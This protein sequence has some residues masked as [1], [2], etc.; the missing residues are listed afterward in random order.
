MRRTA[1]VLLVLA[2][3]GC[4]KKNGGNTPANPPSAYYFKADIN[5][6]SW[7][8]NVYFAEYLTY[9]LGV[10]INYNGVNYMY[11]FSFYAANGDTSQSMDLLFPMNVPVNTPIAFDSAANK[12]IAYAVED[13]LK[14]GKFDGWN[15]AAPTGGS[16][17][18]TITKLDQGN[19]IVEGT[20]SGTLGSLNGKAAAKVANGTFS[21]PYVLEQSQLPPNVKVSIT[22]RLLTLRY[23]L[24]I[25]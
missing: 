25:Q 2:C 20:F 11:V 12:S 24:H 6:Q 17:T 22:Q 13:P 5:G 16:G 7:A 15:A 19:R 18:F 10:V 14:S 9:P 3:F 23:A 4:S 21:S 8:A 1:F